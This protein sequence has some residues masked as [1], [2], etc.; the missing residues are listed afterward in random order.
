[1]S[2]EKS[3]AGSSKGKYYVYTLAY[4]DEQIFYVGKGQGKR[5]HHH[6]AEARTGCSCNKCQTIRQ[7][8][9]NGEQV[10][11]SIVFETCKEQEALE[12]EEQLINQHDGSLLVNIISN[13][14]KGYNVVD[15]TRIRDATLKGRTVHGVAVVSTK[16]MLEIFGVKAS[17]LNSC[18]CS[19][20]VMRHK[21]PFDSRWYIFR[22]DV[23]RVQ[24]FLVGE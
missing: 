15:K 4:P 21:F 7:V 11:K 23:E 20:N 16:E 19:A 17:L 22:S 5:V 8:W 10:L 9:K 13:K 2:D 18:L 6:E 1:M 14:S 3:I 12:Q 24:R